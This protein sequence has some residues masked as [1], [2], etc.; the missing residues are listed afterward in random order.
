MFCIILYSFKMYADCKVSV[1]LNIS[2]K[3]KI[4]EEALSFPILYTNKETLSKLL[5]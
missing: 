4:L 2:N 5:I 3:D 1:S